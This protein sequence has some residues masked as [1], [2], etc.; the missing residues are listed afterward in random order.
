MKASI[1]IIA[2]MLIT[3]SAFGQLLD[4]KSELK[5]EMPVFKDYLFPDFSKYKKL[6]LQGFGEISVPS[7]NEM[8]LDKIFKKKKEDLRILRLDKKFEIKKQK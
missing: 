6:T 5:T 7:L 1:I 3:T 8:R 4:R 2:L